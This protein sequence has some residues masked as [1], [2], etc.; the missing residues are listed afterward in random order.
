MMVLRKLICFVKGHD[1]EQLDWDFWS[2]NRCGMVGPMDE[3]AITLPYLYWK[4]RDLISNLRIR[5]VRVIDRCP[6]CR[7]ITHVFGREIHPEKHYDCI[8]F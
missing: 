3:Y 5:R 8:P 6:D 2:C 1:G 7:K 4:L